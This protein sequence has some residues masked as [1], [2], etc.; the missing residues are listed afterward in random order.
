M[1]HTKFECIWTNGYDV[2]D[3]SF[4]TFLSMHHNDHNFH[5]S[6]YYTEFNRISLYLPNKG[7]TQLSDNSENFHCKRSKVKV[8]VSKKVKITIL[9]ITS[10]I[11]KIKT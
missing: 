5:S 10:V 2:I 6:V 3:V 4:F 9:V 1:S 11:I 8:K 7:G